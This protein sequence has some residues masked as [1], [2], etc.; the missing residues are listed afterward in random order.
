MRCTWRLSNGTSIELPP[1]S[2]GSLRPTSI[3]PRASA[4]SN[5]RRR[6]IPTKSERSSS[7]IRTG[8]STARMTHMGRRTT[9]R[10]RLPKSRPT[11]AGTGASSSLTMSCIH[12]IW[13]ARSA[14]CNCRAASW[15][16]SIAGMPSRS[17]RGPGRAC[18]ERNASLHQFLHSLPDPRRIEALMAH[19]LPQAAR[20]LAVGAAVVVAALEPGLQQ[21]TAEA[22][23]E[24]GLDVPPFRDQHERHAGQRAH[25]LRVDDVDRGLVD[26]AHFDALLL[27]ADDRIERAVDRFA[28]RDDIAAAGR[29]FAHDVILAGLERLAL[30]QR[31]AI[32]PENVGDGC[33]GGEHEAQPGVLEDAFDAGGKLVL[34]G[35][36]VEPGHVGAVHR[37]HAAVGI[38][39]VDTEVT[40]VVG[41]VVDAAVAEVR[42]HVREVQPR[43]RYLAD[44]HLEKGAE[45]CVYALLAG[46]RTE[47]GGGGIVAA[48]HYFDADE[49]LRMF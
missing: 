45:G 47:A 46:D 4:I 42:Q 11:G 21:V 22:A 23:A 25:H 12:R 39:A 10:R 19:L 30:V 41:H 40:G 44:A 29:C 38:H 27:Q 13:T 1:S 32:L 20:A 18:G 24:P 33:P 16:R 3:W 8:S 43:H 49:D 2:I 5:T 14:A 17:S 36:E 48:L 35:R 6:L 26:Q 9:I 31:L 15:T 7:A 37:Q 34:V 28:H